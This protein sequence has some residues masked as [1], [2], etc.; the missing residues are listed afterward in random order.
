MGFGKMD[1]G[2]LSGYTELVE[3]IR[4]DDLEPLLGLRRHQTIDFD[5]AEIRTPGQRSEPFGGDHRR[6]RG[7]KSESSID[8]QIADGHEIGQSGDAVIEGV[9]NRPQSRRIGASVMGAE[10]QLRSLGLLRRIL[11]RI[12][13][14][15]LLTRGPVVERA[16]EFFDGLYDFRE[17]PEKGR[18]FLKTL[19]SGV[20]LLRVR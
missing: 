2:S 17:H 18:T 19:P 11:S 5:E 14:V 16:P 12:P 15:L 10:D 20:G 6:D 4:S 13:Q 1:R 7:L 9:A 8:H 3:A